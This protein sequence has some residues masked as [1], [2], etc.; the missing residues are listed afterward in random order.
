MFHPVGP[1][2]PGEGAE[3]HPA[4]DRG[5]LSGAMMKGMKGQLRGSELYLYL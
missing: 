3:F 4:G 2:I 5:H 1:V